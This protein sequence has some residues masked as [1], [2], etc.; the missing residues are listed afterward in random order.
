VDARLHAALQPR[1]RSSAQSCALL[2]PPARG[3]GEVDGGC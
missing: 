1:P 2:H 3:G